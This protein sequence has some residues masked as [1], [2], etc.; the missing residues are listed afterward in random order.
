VSGYIVIQCTGSPVKFERSFSGLSGRPI[1]W[2]NY[3]YIWQ[4]RKNRRGQAD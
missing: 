3:D 2:I 4:K 1:E